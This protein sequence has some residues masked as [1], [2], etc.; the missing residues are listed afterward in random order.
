IE[1]K[2]KSNA[3]LPEVSSPQQ[4]TEPE[5]EPEDDASWLRDSQEESDDVDLDEELISSSINV[6]LR[7]MDVG[8]YNLILMVVDND[9]AQDTHEI[10]LSVNAEPKSDSGKFNIAAIFMFIGIVA[11]SFMMFRRMRMT[12]NEASVLPKW[13][14][15]SK[16]KSGDSE[17]DL[18]IGE[19]S[20]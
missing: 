12:G 19:E 13:E 2:A 15:G 7:D 1:P 11:F 4:N 14:S 9:G 8:E 5:I 6:T 3:D 16:I 17:N 20:P 10:Q 18:W